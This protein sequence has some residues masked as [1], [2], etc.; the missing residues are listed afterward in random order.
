MT[1]LG[2]ILSLN[3]VC[4]FQSRERVGKASKSEI[5]RWILNGAVLVNGEKL[6]WDEEIDFPVNSV[7]L[8]PNGKRVSL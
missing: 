4:S 7:T 1:G 3:E 6:I 2:Y 8:F 5:R